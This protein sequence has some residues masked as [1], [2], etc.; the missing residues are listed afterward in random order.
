M[1]VFSSFLTKTYHNRCVELL[2]SDISRKKYVKHNGK[3]V[4]HIRHVINVMKDKKILIRD[5]CNQTLF[6]ANLLGM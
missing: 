5:M 1:N 3:M 6:R 4:F 2:I